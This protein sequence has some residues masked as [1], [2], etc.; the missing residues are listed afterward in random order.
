MLS[1]R[2]TRYKSL[3]FLYF[4]RNR[5][6]RLFWTS[7][8]LFTGHPSHDLSI[9]RLTILQ[10]DF[11]VV[12]AQILAVPP[13]FHYPQRKILLS[14]FSACHLKWNVDRGRTSA[15]SFFGRVRYHD[16]KPCLRHSAGTPHHGNTLAQFFMWCLVPLSCV[17]LLVQNSF[18]MMCFSKRVLRADAALL[19][20]VSR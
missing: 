12:G 3:F 14:L 17:A 16:F 19:K 20:R 15:Q 4:F 5:L 8:W 1:V 10:T 18:E 2:Y 9:Q 7:S 11:E 6:S 13:D